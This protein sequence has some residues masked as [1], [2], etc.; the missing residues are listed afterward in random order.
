MVE[1]GGQPIIWHILKSFSA[2]GADRFILCLGYRRELFVDYF[3]NYRARSSDI[4][5]RLG[6]DPATIFHECNGAPEDWCVTLPNTGEATMTGGRIALA[7]RHLR[8][9]ESE[10]FLTYGDGVADVD[11]AR[12]LAFHRQ[13]GKAATVCAVH[14]A[15]RFGDIEIEE[16][17]AVS[18][19]EKRQTASGWINGGFMVL[20]RR[21]VETYLSGD[22]AEVLEQEPMRRA[23]QDGEIAAYKHE[24]FW[25]CMDTPRE[26]QLLNELWQSGS[27]PWKD[28]W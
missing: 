20:T 25:Q 17:T 26:H 22:A 10:F 3:L 13:E 1:I 6:R 24:G 18:F 21:F 7:R 15:G 28:A 11:L 8:D 19:H 16:N 12:L 27:A 14:P 9:G 23:A 4:T 5:V 2:Y